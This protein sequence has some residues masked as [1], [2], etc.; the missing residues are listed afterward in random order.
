MLAHAHLCRS[1]C[2]PSPRLAKSASHSSRSRKTA[3]SEVASP[4]FAAIGAALFSAVGSKARHPGKAELERRARL[5]RVR[6]CAQRPRPHGARARG[7]ATLMF[8]TPPC[9]GADF[10]VE[11]P[12]DAGPPSLLPVRGGPPYQLNVITPRATAPVSN[13]RKPSLISSKA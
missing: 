4:G 12:A 7:L 10:L 1:R 2:Y 9:R 6:A 8:A 13:S 11:A 5:S 3:P